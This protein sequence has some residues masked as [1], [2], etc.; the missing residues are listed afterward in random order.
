[1]P[2]QNTRRRIMDGSERT[3]KRGEFLKFDMNAALEMR[4]AVPGHRSNTQITNGVIPWLQGSETCWEFLIELR[5]TV[6]LLYRHTQKFA[7][8]VKGTWVKLL[9]RHT[10]TH[11]PV[12]T[13]KVSNILERR[14]G[15]TAVPIHT[16][17]CKHIRKNLGPT[18][19]QTHS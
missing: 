13:H 10:H 19:V 11:T 5:T 17:V 16:K 9:L 7:T 15:Q 12:H 1:M 18:A 6:T 4:M 14:K 3:A 2:A 8:Y